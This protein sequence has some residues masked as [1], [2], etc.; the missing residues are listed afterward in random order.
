[1][2]DALHPLGVMLTD[3]PLTSERVWRAISLARGRPAR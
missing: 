3:Q 2:N 1:V